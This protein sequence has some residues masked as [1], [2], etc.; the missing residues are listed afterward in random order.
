M[1]M[2][3]SFF[4]ALPGCLMKKYSGEKP[5]GILTAVMEEGRKERSRNMT[6]KKKLE[7]S[8]NTE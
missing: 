4:F 6:K 2:G 7:Q 1:L 3:D 8:S 5:Q